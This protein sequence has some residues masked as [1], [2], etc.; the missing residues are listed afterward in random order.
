MLLMLPFCQV[1]PEVQR[2]LTDEFYPPLDSATEVKRGNPVFVLSIFVHFCSF[3]VHFLFIFVYICSIPCIII[4]L[5]Y[6]LF[7]SRPP[8]ICTKNNRNSEPGSHMYAGR[9]MY[10][11][12]PRRLAASCAP[13]QLVPMFSP[14][15]IPY[16]SYRWETGRQWKSIIGRG[17]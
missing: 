17:Y 8:M 7:L 4:A 12:C 15:C 6:L 16:L 13:Q 1:R 14:S 3:F 11:L 5:L 9:R 10:G 2:M